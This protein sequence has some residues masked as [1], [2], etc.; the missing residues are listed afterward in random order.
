MTKPGAYFLKSVRAI[1]MPTP[2]A[3]G[4]RTRTFVSFRIKWA[5]DNLLGNIK[6]SQREVYYKRIVGYG[7]AASIGNT[8]PNPQLRIPTLS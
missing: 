5:G 2:G 7:R 6:L 1:A 8:C 4:E 3:A